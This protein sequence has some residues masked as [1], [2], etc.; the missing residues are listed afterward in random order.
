MPILEKHKAEV[1]ELGYQIAG[2]HLEI[3]KAAEHAES[4]ARMAELQA[5]LKALIKALIRALFGVGF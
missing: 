2:I 4:V 1:R 3:K 5:Q